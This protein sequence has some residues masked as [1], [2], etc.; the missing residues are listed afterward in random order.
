MKRI[1]DFGR[2]PATRNHTV[3]DLKALKGSGTTLSMSNPANATELRACVEAGVDLMVVWEENLDESREIAP[4][5]FLGAGSTW[6]QLGTADEILAHAVDLMGR[7]ADMYY[8]LRSFE[9][10]EKLANEGI[11]VQSHIGLIPTYGHW[12][13]GLR[14]YG[15]TA[16]EAMEI[17]RTMR[18]MEDAGVFAVEVEC[19]AEEFLTAVNEKTSLVTFSLGSGP[20]ADAI[21]SFVADVCGEPNEEETPPRHAHA[22]GDLGRLHRQMYTERVAAMKAFHDETTAGNFPYAANNIGMHDGE[23]EKFLEALDAER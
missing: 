10:M 7:G 20:S 3:A 21:F 18:R 19:I 9:V 17:W 4:S 6:K 1:Y 11:P 5:H 8:T 15:R 16:E 22:F 12:A 14:A 13:G 23:H 2:R